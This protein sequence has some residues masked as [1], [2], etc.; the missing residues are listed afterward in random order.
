LADEVQLRSW[1]SY[2][3]SFDN[4][5]RFND[6]TGMAGE[7]ANGFFSFVDKFLSFLGMASG[8]PTT[9]EVTQRKT[10]SY[11]TPENNIM[12]PEQQVG[13]KVVDAMGQTATQNVQNTSASVAEG[14][15]NVQ[16]A[17]DIAT[18]VA[19]VIPGL[20]KAAPV[21][22]GVSTA[23]GVVKTLAQEAH[24]SAGGNRY[25]SD[26]VARSAGETLVGAIGGKVFKENPGGQVFF[27][28]FFKT[29]TR[30]PGHAPTKP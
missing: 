26:D 20:Q 5:M 13:L 15:Q 19:L 8:K 12:T 9:Q 7:D 23:A 28:D 11:V 3:Y 29:I 25:S 6:P 10:D 17:A 4:P 21:T 18:R 1:S 24:V 27:Q 30:N 2:H 16:D 22:L 14:A